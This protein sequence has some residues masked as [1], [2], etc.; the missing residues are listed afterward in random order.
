MPKLT[1]RIEIPT[2]GMFIDYSGLQHSTIL[3]FLQPL[4]PKHLKFSPST[5]SL[6]VYE[7]QFEKV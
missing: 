1:F 3:K 5:V 2:A 4:Q 6:Y 7:E